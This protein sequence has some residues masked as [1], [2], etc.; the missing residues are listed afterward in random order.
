MELEVFSDSSYFDMWCVKQKDCK[1]FD[2]TI[3]F[4]DRVTATHAAQVIETWF[5]ELIKENQS[6]KEE[7][8]K[9]DYLLESK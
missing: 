2:L 1:D 8:R 5:N 7:I 4:M 3:H 6:L 9:L